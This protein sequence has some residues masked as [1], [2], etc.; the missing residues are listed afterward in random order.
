MP[1]YEIKTTVIEEYT[2]EVDSSIYD[3]GDNIC[4]ERE[5][6]DIL[7]YEISNGDIQFYPEILPCRRSVTID[8]VKEK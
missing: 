5:L 6:R 4:S 2:I 1:K 8:E 7:K 3:D